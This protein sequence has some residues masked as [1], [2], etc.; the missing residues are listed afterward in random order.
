MDPRVPPCLHGPPLAILMTVAPGIPY[1][2][3]PVEFLMT[4]GGHPGL[5]GPVAFPMGV[6]GCVLPF[7]FPLPPTNH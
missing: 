1:D 4:V 7:F 2:R 3:G 5:V 6:R